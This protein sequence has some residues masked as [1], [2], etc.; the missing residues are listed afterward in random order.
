MAENQ[1]CCEL[2]LIQLVV[3]GWIRKLQASIGVFVVRSMAEV[4]K[5]TEG[6]GNTWWVLAGHVG[7]MSYKTETVLLLPEQPV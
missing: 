1:S 3:G 2:P 5:K 6:R 4:I 7:E